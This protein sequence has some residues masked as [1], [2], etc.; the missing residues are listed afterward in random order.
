MADQRGAT[1]KKIPAGGG[2]GVQVG[3]GAA[4]GDTVMVTTRSGKTW[5]AKLGRSTGSGIW[6]TEHTEP[7]KGGTRARMEQRA[8]RREDWAESRTASSQAALD[9]AHALADAIPFGQPILVG[10]HSESRARKDVATIDRDMRKGMDDAKMAEHHQQSASGIRH[11][12][13]RSIYDDD[14]DAVEAL[15]AKVAGLEAERDRIKELNQRI[16]KG[17]SLNDLP[18]TP[19]DVKTLEFSAQF[20]GRKGFPPYALQNIG[21]NI[22]NARDRLAKLR[23]ATESQEGPPSAKSDD[24]AASENQKSAYDDGANAATSLRG[25]S[26]PQYVYQ[27]GP[28]EIRHYD[29]GYMAEAMKP[30]RQLEGYTTEQAREWMTEKVD[31]M[32]AQQRKAGKAPSWAAAEPPSKAARIPSDFNPSKG[33]MGILVPD[34]PNAEPMEYY[35]QGNTIRRAPIGQVLDV[36][37]GA[38]AGRSEGPAQLWA[39]NLYAQEVKSQLMPWSSA[40]KA[41]APGSA[42]LEPP[43]MPFPKAVEDRPSVDR[44]PDDYEERLENLRDDL[45]AA[46][47]NSAHGGERDNIRRL[48]QDI[49]QTEYEMAQGSVRAEQVQSRAAGQ[50]G[51]GEEPPAVAPTPPE[52]AAQRE[53]ARRR[54]FDEGLAALDSGKQTNGG[55][56]PVDSLASIDPPAERK[57]AANRKQSEPNI[58]RLARAVANAEDRLAGGGASTVKL[59]RADL[60][61]ARAK[62]RDAMRGKDDDELQRLSIIP[63]LGGSTTGMG[64]TGAGAWRAVAARHLNEVAEEEQKERQTPPMKVTPAARD[65]DLDLGAEVERNKARPP[66]PRVA[67]RRAI[68]EAGGTVPAI[69]DL[70]ELTA[71]RDRLQTGEQEPAWNPP[72]K[73][74]PPQ[75]SAPAG[76]DTLYRGHWKAGVGPLKVDEPERRDGDGD[77]VVRERRPKA[78]QEYQQSPMPIPP[79]IAARL[80]LETPAVRPV[81]SEQAR[82]IAAVAAPPKPRKSSGPRKPR[83]QGLK[84]GPSGADRVIVRRGR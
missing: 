77:T 46:H 23:A 29:D 26:P 58:E 8:N 11:A 60:D 6:T 34:D 67:V 71:I 55:A 42:A 62:L 84:K 25:Y 16:R 37:T 19:A 44:S 7:S 56:V 65:L 74:T 82:R 30:G 15:E 24:K 75:P 20:H 68:R 79:G 27:K 49:A 61:K 48:Q 40:D 9:K 83:D 78:G 13:N 59:R 45:Q 18:L 52:N 22:K 21:G 80:G 76:E 31:G 35:R 69:S 72:P 3:P 32:V 1:P 28:A 4:A 5:E 39:Q 63:V 54:E 73:P 70:A 43:S 64:A 41:A 12:L 2:W 17:E 38:R 50:L 81:V 33:H 66:D 14:D 10:H 51:F 36:D 57:Q 47:V 53:A